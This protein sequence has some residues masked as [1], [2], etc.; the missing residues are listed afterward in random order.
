M[1]PLFALA[2]PTFGQLIAEPVFV[3]VDTAI[4]GHVSTSALAGLSLGSTVI[5]TAVGL[6]V[7]LAYATTSQVAHLLGAGRRREGLQAGM[8]GLWLA[9]A[10]GAGLAAALFALA[11]PLC[12]LLG[13]RGADLQQAVVYARAAALGVPGMLLVYAANG[14]FRGLQKVR[15]TLAVAVAGAALNTVFDVAFVIGCGWGILGSGAATGIAQWFMGLAL[16]VPAVRWA[17][18]GGASARP[19]LAGIAR[20][21]GDGLPLFLRTL[22]LRAGMVATVMAAASM[23][24]DVLAGYQVVNATWNFALNILDAIAIAGQTLVGAQLGAGNFAQARCL[25]RGAARIGLGMGVVVGAAFALAGL[26]APGAFSPSAQVQQLASAGMVA[27]GAG[28]PVQ[29]WMWALDGI[30]IG[31][32]DFRYL[33]R[34]CAAASGAHIAAL[35]VLAVL[36]APQL[37]SDLARTVALWVAFDVVLMGGRALANALRVRTDAWMR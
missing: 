26:V 33:A 18:A 3:L 36:V 31:A 7:F 28:L 17:R 27:V 30:L 25:T 8:D 2:L 34:A 12:W 35:L 32:G 19:R 22:A 5:L 21:G 37:S 10:I 23:G 24:T 13:G 4:V 9:A 1:K 29:G 16:V 14:V 20:A 6:C 15:I 11:E